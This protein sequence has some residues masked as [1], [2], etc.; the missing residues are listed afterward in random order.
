ME[1]RNN[2]GSID[3]Y[4]SEY[5]REQLKQRDSYFGESKESF[6]AL[7]EEALSKDNVEAV[8]L[9]KHP[10]T[11]DIPKNVRTLTI[12]INPHLIRHTTPE[13]YLSDTC[14]IY[15]CSSHTIER[16]KEKNSLYIITGYRTDNNF[17]SV[18][19]TEIETLQEALEIE[20][21]V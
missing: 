11:I 10:S 19:T 2:D 13:K 9:H 3:L 20:L 8:T 17:F 14:L 12:E 18:I 1:V 21:C 4:D 7:L 6:V 16:L 15:D 5:L